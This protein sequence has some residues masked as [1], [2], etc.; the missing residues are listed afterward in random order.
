MAVKKK[1]TTKNKKEMKC[2]TGYERV[3][4]TKAGSKGSCRKKK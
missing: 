4:G 1:A 3:P 2:W